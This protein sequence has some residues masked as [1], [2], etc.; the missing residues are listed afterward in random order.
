MMKSR[1]PFFILELTWLIVAIFCAVLG[2]YMLIYNKNNFNY[3]LFIL[4]ALSLLM[5]FMRRYMRKNNMYK[6]KEK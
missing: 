6:Q 5:Y 4:C 1:K 2:T 3:T